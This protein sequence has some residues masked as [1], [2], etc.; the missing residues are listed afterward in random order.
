MHDCLFDV[1]FAGRK[2]VEEFGGLTQEEKQQRNRMAY[3][4]LPQLRSL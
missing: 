4:N 3:V 2:L 1:R